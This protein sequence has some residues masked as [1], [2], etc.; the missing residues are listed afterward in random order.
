MALAAGEHLGRY[1]ILSLIGKGG[2]GEVYRAFD[3][4][5]QRE[6]AIKIVAHDAAGSGDAIRRFEQ[7][8]RAIARLSHPNVVAVHD[9]GNEK[10]S[11]FIVS[12]L[13]EGQT[14]RE[15]LAGG[16]L[17]ARTAIDYA[18]QMTSALSAAHERGIVHRDLKPENVMV[19]RD[20][21]V[22]VLD[23]GLAKLQQDQPEHVSADAPTAVLAT[24]PGTV[25]GTAG[26]MSPEQLRGATVDARSDLFSLGVVLYEMVEGH[27]PFGGASVADMMAAVLRNDPPRLKAPDTRALEPVIRRCLDKDPGRRYASAAEV[28]G[29]LDGIGRGSTMVPMPPSFPSAGRW[30]TAAVMV[31]ALVT[32]VALT[33]SR[34]R[35]P[36]HSVKAIA[37]LPFENVTGNPDEDYFADGM[38]DELITSVAQYSGIRVIARGSVMPYRK[39]KKPL[40]TIARELG[41]DALVNGTVRRDGQRVRV[42]AEMVPAGGKEVTWAKSYEGT[43]ADALSLQSSVAEAIAQQI[44]AHATLSDDAKKSLSR[45]VDPEAFLLY[46]KGR[47][48]WN[49]R[50]AAALRHGIE[51]FQQAIDRDPTYAAAYSGL[52]DCYTALGYGSFLPPREAF[53][54]AKSAALKAIELD[55]ALAEPHASL[56]Y[57]RLYYDWD[58]AAADAEFHRALA[59]NPNYLTGHQ[60]Y[61]VYLTAMGRFDDAR[62]QIAIARELDP[63]SISVNTDMGFELFYK[64][65]YDAAIRQLLDTIEMN[66]EFALAHFWLGRAYQQSRRY[67]DAIAEYRK[68]ND[69][70]P[71]WVPTLAAL[72]SVYALS[73]QTSDARGVLQ[74]LEE[75]SKAKYVTPY[76]VALI[77]ANLN[78]ANLNDANQAFLW[79]DRAVEDRSHWL[80][81]LKLDARW[82]PIRNDPRFGLLVKKVGL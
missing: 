70:Q 63:L 65:D 42:S 5:L 35:K 80:V 62:H 75:L 13:L 19:L 4:S 73:G 7:E 8:A 44:Q 2:M 32:G 72:G 77:Y 59:L 26:Y 37:V 58:F 11:L 47:Y 27:R 57:V 38:T 61:S 76:G 6:V 55:P 30:I 28:R 34:M 48:F 81:W 41:V 52:A 54:K 22:K 39:T 67:D 49:Q 66:P 16:A 29:A 17:P 69:L 51:V 56:G 50:N 79:L 68:A 36:V 43:L 1:E 3:A 60:F 23:F 31:L 25:M 14:L 20:G 74:H 21:T 45:R 10:G 40:E 53:T 33:V 9:F 18:L 24:T 64:S 82:Q 46:Q 71:D 15:R 78:D 12:E